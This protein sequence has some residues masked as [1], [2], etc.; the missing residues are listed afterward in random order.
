MLRPLLAAAIFVASSALAFPKENP[1]AQQQLDNARRPADLF[2]HATEPF[3]L[4][5]DF[6]TQLGV[7]V[8]GQLVV[9]WK[10]KDQWWSKV[11]LGPFQQIT[12]RHGEEEYTLRNAEV[13]PIA[14]KDLFVLLQLT[15]LPFE[16]SAKKQTDKTENGVALTC[17]QAQ[18]VDKK[19]ETNEFC[20]D[21]ASHD[22]LSQEWRDSDDIRH[23][24]KYSDFVDFEGVR[25]PRQLKFL[26]NQRLA[27]SVAITKLQ[28]APFDSALLTPPAGSIERRHCVGVKPPMPLKDTKSAIGLSSFGSAIFSLTILTDG[29]VGEIHL[30]G[31]AKELMNDPR[32]EGMKQW[33]FTPAMCGNDPIVFDLQVVINS[34][35]T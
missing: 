21:P 1:T 25:Y 6:T 10:S 12:V 18:R 22:V 7:P 14:V 2:T 3:E 28:T 27:I 30:I 11:I 32:I 17:I 4:R 24:R 15:Q 16:F 31:G 29:S 23:K 19:D 33:K 34:H 20:L 9:K 35:H 5:L 26:E 8:Q 13:T